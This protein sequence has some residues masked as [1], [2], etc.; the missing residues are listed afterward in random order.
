MN[1]VDKKKI[2]DGVNDLD[3]YAENVLFSFFQP[4]FEL[5]D[6]NRWYS[7]QVL[8]DTI[9]VLPKY[10]RLID[11]FLLIINGIN[12]FQFQDGKFK[13]LRIPSQ[14]ELS[15]SLGI[16]RDNLLTHSVSFGSN[17]ELLDHCILSYN[18]ILRGEIR[19]D[20]MLFSEKAL[21]IEGKIYRENIAAVFFNEFL[22]N[23]VSKI[24]DRLS[25]N[26]N[27]SPIRILEIGAGTGR[28]S[29]E[30]LKVFSKSGTKV[31][32][33]YTDAS[34]RFVNFGQEKFGKSNPFM[35]F[36]VLDIQKDP[37]EYKELD[38]SC[39]I[40]FA[41]NAIHGTS[42]ITKSLSN[43]NFLLKDNGILIL[44]EKTEVSPFLMM[45]SG[46]A[47]SWWSYKDDLRLPGSPLLSKESWRIVMAQQ[48]FG[49][50]KGYALNKEFQS[51]IVGEKHH[52]THELSNVS[53]NE[54]SKS[55]YLD[56]QHDLI[57]LIA[58]LLMVD[59]QN[60]DSSQS[61][62]D[63]GM[64]SLI[65]VSFIDQINELFDINLKVTLV[66]QYPDIDS[67]SQ[68][69]ADHVI[70]TRNPI[71]TVTSEE[72]IPVS[73]FSMS[74][75]SFE[76]KQKNE[77]SEFN[78]KK[79]IEPIAII[80][81]S[82]RFPGA[83]NLQQYWDNLI[84][85]KIEFS[86]EV[87]HWDKEDIKEYGCDQDEM[88]KRG[89][90]LSDIDLFDALFFEI[91]PLEARYMDPQQRLF[92]EES[93]KAIEDAGYRAGS[94]KGANCGVYVGAG[95]SDY[96]YS[97]PNSI[98]HTSLTGNISSIL[99]ARISY[100]LD[101]KGPSISID[102]ACSSSL[103][104]VNM[105]CDSLRN[106]S[107][108][109]ALAGGISLFLTPRFHS[110]AGKTG[111][112][113]KTGLC[114]PFDNDANGIVPGEAVGI[115]M[116][117]RLSDAIRDKDNIYAVIKGNG[118]NQDG[119]SNGIT[120]PNPVAQQE[121]Q[122]SIYRRFDIDPSKI[123]YVETH[124]TGTE[125]GDPI[126]ITALTDSFR[127][128]TSQHKFCAISSVKGNIGHTL[129]AAGISSLIK[130]VLAFKHK[131]IPAIANFSTE[132][133]HIKF[134][135]SPFYLVKNKEPW[136]AENGIRMAA[137]NAFGMSGTNCHM[138]LEEYNNF[139]SEQL[140][141]ASLITFS[142]KDK[143][144]L[145][146]KITEFKTWFGT[147]KD[148]V[149]LNDIIFTLNIGRDHF[150]HRAV[151]VFKGKE[152][153]LEKLISEEITYNSNSLVV[154]QEQQQGNWL[155]TVESKLE[156]SKD[157]LASGIAFHYLNG[158]NIR[159]ENFYSNDF[160]KRISLPTYP[161][162]GDRYWVKEKQPSINN[163]G[164]T[165]R[166][167]SIHDKFVAQHII[168][169]VFV[170]PGVAIIEF[171]R[172]AYIA[173]F[174][175]SEYNWK[176]IFYI[177]PIVID[178]KYGHS[179]VRFTELDNNVVQFE[180]VSFVNDIAHPNAKG[181]ISSQVENWDETIILKSIKSNAN[182][183][184]ENQNIYKF[185]ERNGIS[186]GPSFRLINTMYVSD[187]SALA[188]IESGDQDDKYFYSPFKLD[189]CFQTIMGIFDA[190]D[191]QGDL[192]VPVSFDL[193]QLPDKL[194][195]NFFAYATKSNDKYDV[196]LFDINGCSI[197][198]IVG[199][200]AGRLTTKQLS[201]DSRLITIENNWV[202]NNYSD[203]LSVLKDNETVLVCSQNTAHHDSIELW[204]TSHFPK[205]KLIKLAKGMHFEQSGNTFSVNLMDESSITMLF[206]KL[207]QNIPD[208]M[209]WI[210]EDGKSTSNEMW[211]NA[212]EILDR[213]IISFHH[214]LQVWYKFKKG[215]KR[216]LTVF[217]SGALYRP[218]YEMYSGY[219][220][221]IRQENP[222]T[223]C[224]TLQIEGSLSDYISEL[225]QE[226]KQADFESKFN[227]DGRS[228]NEYLVKNI[229]DPIDETNT[230]R[231]KGVYL[232]CGGLGGI[233]IKLCQY[234]LK[235]YDAKLIVAGRSSLENIQGKL[236]DLGLSFEDYVCCDFTNMNEVEH[237]Y[238]NIKSR[239]TILNGVFFL[240]GIIQDEYLYLKSTANF[241][242]VVSTK[243]NGVLN[244]DH[245][246]RFEPLD[247]FCAFSSLSSLYGNEGQGD[248]SCANSFLNSFSNHRNN[249]KKT[250]GRHG[251]TLA[252]AWPLW[253][254]GMQV[255]NDMKDHFLSKTGMQ[256]LETDEGFSVMETLLS[257]KE[258]MVGIFK[259]NIN[260][261]N[262]IPKTKIDRSSSINIELNSDRLFEE[263]ALQLISSIFSEAVGLNVSQ[264]D[265]E[266]N[267]EMFGLNSLIVATLNEAFELKFGSLSRT[268]F[269]EYFNL[270]E[271]TNYFIENHQN[272]LEQLLSK[273]PD[274]KTI[275]KENLNMPEQLLSQTQDNKTIEKENHRD[276]ELDTDGQAKDS[277]LNYLRDPIAIVGM[278]GKY[279]GANDLDDFWSQ[280]SNGG[281]MVHDSVP[282]TWKLSGLKD[283]NVSNKGGF[284]NEHF[285]FD[286]LY[287]NISPREA[288][289]MDPQERLF[290]MECHKAIEAAGYSAES[291][292]Y[293]NKG[294]NQVG[295][296]AGVMWGSYSFFGVEEALKGDNTFPLSTYY[297]VANRVSSSLNFNGPSIAFDT[298]CSSSLTALHYACQSILIG[299][300]DVALAGG[301][302]LALHPINHIVLKERGFLSPNG[303]CN[304]FGEGGEGY[305]PSEGVGV[306]VL[307]RL[308]QAKSDGD[309][310]YGVIRAS[311][312]NHGGKTT[313]YTV[314]NPTKQGTLIR[315]VIEKSGIDPAAL[316]YIEAHGTGT[317]LGDPIEIN[318]LR[319]ALEGY[320]LPNQKC[321]IG[322]VK[323]NLG[324]LEAASGMA[325]L[326]K[327]ILQIKNQMLVPS[328]HAER[329]NPG[330]NFQESEFYLNQK[331]QPWLRNEDSK[332]NNY[333]LTAGLSSFGAGGSNAH[334][335]IE[336][337]IEKNKNV[338]DSNHQEN[339]SVAWII[340][341]QDEKQLI[342]KV[343]SLLNHVERN[344][345]SLEQIAYTLQT[346]RMNLAARIGFIGSNRD[347]LIIQLIEFIEKRGESSITEQSINKRQYL[348][349]LEQGDLKCLVAYWTQG[350]KVDWKSLYSIPPQRVSLPVHPFKLKKYWFS[351]I[352]TPNESKRE[353]ELS[354]LNHLF[355]KNW[356]TKELDFNSKRDVSGTTLV[357]LTENQ[358]NNEF[359]LVENQF[360]NFLFVI[361]GFENLILSVGKAI[362]ID[363]QNLDHQFF[364]NVVN[365][366][367]NT[368]HLIDLSNLEA[369]ETVS[370][371]DGAMC[372]FQLFQILVKEN[373]LNGMKLHYFTRELLICE[374][375]LSHVRGAMLIGTVKAIGAEYKKIESKVIDIST[376]SCTEAINIAKSEFHSNDG[377]TEIC[378]R[379]GT[380]LISGFEKVPLKSETKRHEI[381]ISSEYFYIITGGTSGIGLSLVKYLIEKGARKILLTGTGALP[382]VQQWS[383]IMNSPDKYPDEI[384]KK[385]SLLMDYQSKNVEF[386]VY[387]GSLMDTHRFGN[388]LDKLSLRWGTLGGCM[389][390]AGKANY[391]EPAFINKTIGKVIEVF[392]P[393]VSGL[394][395]LDR[396]LAPLKPKFVVLFSSSSVIPVLGVGA[397]EYAGANEFMD[398]FVKSKQNVNG[399]RYSS[400]NWTSWKASGSGAIKGEFYYKF[401]FQAFDNDTGFDLL[402]KAMSSSEAVVFA[403][404]MENILIPADKWLTVQPFSKIE[405][406]LVNSQSV[407]KDER[408]YDKIK[409]KYLVSIVAE[410]L[411]VQE[412]DI[413]IS[414]PLEE[415]GIDLISREVIIK[416]LIEYSYDN[417]ELE[418]SLTLSSSI[419]D[420]CKMT[421]SSKVIEDNYWKDEI[422]QKRKFED[423]VTKIL[424][425][426]LNLDDEQ[427]DFDRNFADYG[428]DSILLAE[429]VSKIEALVKH[430]IDPSILLDNDTLSQ[431]I[432]YLS[433]EFL[434][435]TKSITDSE[436]NNINDVELLISE[437]EITSMDIKDFGEA[438]E[439]YAFE[440]LKK[441]FYQLDNR[442]GESG[443]MSKNDFQSRLGIKSVFNPLF[444]AF[445]DILEKKDVIKMDENIITFFKSEI[446]TDNYLERTKL[447]LK[448]A[449][450]LMEPHINFVT[451]CISA[452]PKILKGEIDPVAVVFQSGD[453][454]EL[455]KVYS[456][457]PQL[458]ELNRQIGNSISGYIQQ[459]KGDDAIRIL[460][461]GA[462][463]GSTSY[464]VL[465]Q[466]KS[467][468]KTIEY[469]F[470]DVSLSFLKNAE[471]KLQKEFPNVIYK[472]F[473][474]ESSGLKQG[475]DYEMFDIVIAS[476]VLHATTSITNTLGN[477]NELLMPGGR[478][479]VLE[480][481]KYSSLS[482]YT[483][484]LLEG[485]W[486]FEDN[487]KRIEHSPLINIENW[488][489]F[490]QKAGMEFSKLYPEV[491]DMEGYFDYRVFI[492]SKPKM[493][494]DFLNEENLNSEDNKI[495][496]VGL[497]CKFASANNQ[498]EFWESLINNESLISE[499]LPERWEKEKW[500]SEV[501]QSDKSDSCWGGFING[502]E[503]FDNHYFNMSEELAREVDP[504]AR[505]ILEQCTEALSDS[506]YT[507]DEISKRNIGVFIGARKS[508]YK[509]DKISP[510]TII[511]L[512]QNMIAAHVAHFFNLKG[513]A[514]VVD[515]AC[516]SS[517]VSLHLAVQSISTGEC[518]WAIAGGVDLLL[519]ET[520]YLLLSKANVISK[521]DKSYAF[522][523]RANGFVPGEGA[524]CV[525]LKKMSDAIK[526]GD[527]IYAVID[528][529]ATNNDGKTMGI[530]TPNHVA[531]TDVIKTAMAKN[532]LK[533]IDIN[534]IEAHG[535]GTSIGDPIELKS[536]TYAFETEKRQFCGVST[537]KTN[538]GH[539]LCGAGI[540]SFIKMSLC[541]KNQKWVPTL[542]AEFPNPRFDFEN[543]PFYIQQKVQ[544]WNSNDTPVQRAG[545]S[546][547]GFGGTNAHVI[548]SE[549]RDKDH[550]N[551]N[552]VRTSLSPPKWDKKRL[553]YDFIDKY[554]VIEEIEPA[555][556]ITE[557]EVEEINMESF[558]SI[559]E[560]I[561]DLK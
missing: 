174:S 33:I 127:S 507:A 537:V 382:E 120:A 508:S 460:E 275:E 40:V 430:P 404:E 44:N 129:Q 379:N 52:S 240:P 395:N 290:L 285:H 56:I 441:A 204:L 391:D 84:E 362:V 58:N 424:K 364:K 517:L 283:M 36:R 193:L 538:I 24:V 18:K 46:L 488:K 38:K 185:W 354:K 104:A 235:E 183:T 201:A 472:I 216:V 26:K 226:L 475:L 212:Y 419:I 411:E 29:I 376:S 87:E 30:V 420:N 273:T 141:E 299:E 429:M 480:L 80:G 307:K 495:A 187:N 506:G 35:D 196:I 453:L 251:K 483:F 202:I 554:S 223:I 190:G 514:L 171:V 225:F 431:L 209:I 347:D 100:F 308:S 278:S 191:S 73:N 61:F 12:D 198:R 259:G 2:I 498:Q 42:V 461:I 103:A 261:F 301:V 249:V 558:F 267:F 503:Y 386:E 111:M 137:I 146:Q 8:F 195:N 254:D 455:Q 481:V 236:T 416:S 276:S 5:F 392:E 451:R 340:S 456:E 150:K 449:S 476:N 509:P 471:R 330:I 11:S 531:Q 289:L 511:G 161:F 304:S 69:I 468:D 169:G 497:S 269:F 318:G 199:I 135:N 425:D 533:G 448:R 459:K 37:S 280:L 443:S 446:S 70:I 486:K 523:K 479:Y 338:S 219:N 295:V 159:W 274:N 339:G 245:V 166:K 408:I 332:G 309:S 260:H 243:V 478:L 415:L 1:T 164:F 83:K 165:Q 363:I 28:T 396:L 394:I 246:T 502:V 231:K 13:I 466:L 179:A 115:V 349:G 546:S 99:A 519:D 293:S 550:L 521:S 207:G 433:A 112:L 200:N 194:P 539:L 487:Q 122:E 45:T 65:G 535:T 81:M 312:I 27:I 440:L 543:S 215:S 264:I 233:G 374:V 482:T 300:C 132:N 153:L 529:T 160:G 21:E 542:N 266:A 544:S 105:A 116:L 341:A 94:L 422:S 524:G 335:I 78:D 20:E 93:Y 263:R 57:K 298:A 512:G 96:D 331:L 86:T 510:N 409:M 149:N 130:L 317:S 203:N 253:N 445:L 360:E 469:Y 113:S 438:I 282:E 372:K 272:K 316:G 82:G 143:R 224:S 368:E 328:I 232:V 493:K 412:S 265:T 234:L 238:Y 250:G 239:F 500:Y 76:I 158:E 262:K 284:I 148:K 49:Y 370:D 327:V 142:G 67:L 64:D 384:I 367:Q 371:Y 526:D 167:F 59:E 117:K 351:D 19:Y 50:S 197:G 381:E 306:V 123:S 229:V 255:G 380:R 353:K 7:K 136:I 515:T 79:E 463:T 561:N 4:Y 221:T 518:D 400:V 144:A 536:L 437:S 110:L 319:R 552:K 361:L 126:E 60:I 288:S 426:T 462:G 25:T 348:E 248:Y 551:Y 172:E 89:A 405:T 548:I 47:D 71:F 131:V 296:F 151:V 383:R 522:D 230:I 435:K 464:P 270:T 532:N 75:T 399:T 32:Y 294:E 268:L 133:S 63:Y 560:L 125:L 205:V 454:L 373:R 287:F 15:S 55:E 313:G 277:Q 398:Y 359:D 369:E 333:P 321:A 525:I 496:V 91:S 237:L 175:K 390:C 188:S 214:L 155:S 458:K 334:V 302:N 217:E 92:L 85:E 186:F 62:A 489:I 499:V 343:Q 310:I 553:W 407:S 54:E 346:G 375:S 68:Y 14:E 98:S 43:L 189:A 329:I 77:L 118:L 377:Y 315:N 178:G 128:Y 401:G 547:F 41:S 210:S 447:K 413:D 323:S 325:G 173:R 403:A 241:R 418:S 22:A 279:A 66:Y 192:F 504:A 423:A 485:W 516:S 145:L 505:L 180:V 452:Y 541:L 181:I 527:N 154:S 177:E 357:V 388:V 3:K 314:P 281:N 465:E 16:L 385:I 88:L 556:I 256:P 494:K 72:H 457:D 402:E 31:E 345:F 162:Q 337:Y 119:K 184:I 358:Y 228:I 213:E 9:D 74:Q 182:H 467:V 134:E 227:V 320:N 434:H 414:V 406:E 540:A 322:S 211:Q 350:N 397:S 257:Q 107:I 530:T 534:H 311:G 39:D 163:D 474:V 170:V 258:G 140:E 303:R 520:P 138:V 444:D 356:W 450:V 10:N 365:S 51:I 305:V 124:G 490:I 121:L 97:S 470:T 484:G 410:I 208:Y 108:D 297:A 393:K 90:F 17:V 326:M 139:S 491:M 545:I 439:S 442:F 387:N 355:R 417:F 6:A 152:D 252:L 157:D 95:L 421:I 106:G 244:V 501:S 352:E 427:I 101:L 344:S 218:F 528:G 220:R 557:P 291:I 428:V 513:P 292:K 147:H 549:F 206:E 432:G 247:F 286:P 222:N 53:S 48:G 156:A 366:I 559:K 114:K 492:S 242:N 324:H 336:E 168:H 378:Y 436:S 34:A 473:D 102:T 23:T 477:V 176:D 342:E 555:N 389:H 109:M 271:L